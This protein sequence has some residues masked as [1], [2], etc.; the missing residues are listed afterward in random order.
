MLS[1]KRGRCPIKLVRQCRS[2]SRSLINASPSEIAQSFK[3]ILRLVV[4]GNNRPG[5]A[6]V[7]RDKFLLHSAQ[8]RLLLTEI[9]WQPFIE[10]GAHILQA[11]IIE[12]AYDDSQTCPFP[13][14][15]GRMNVETLK[16]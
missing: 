11:I 4:F 14:C 7:M 13:L 10:S 15:H 5:S 8:D 2:V 6:H 16:W 3:D 12:Q 1:V 9:N